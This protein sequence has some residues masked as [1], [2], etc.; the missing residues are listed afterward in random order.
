YPA[1]PVDPAEPEVWH[2]LATAT[3]HLDGITV[4]AADLEGLA[5]FT[6]TP[7]VRVALGHHVG[8]GPDRRTAAG[9]PARLPAFPPRLAAQCSALGR[10][11]AGGFLATG[12]RAARRG[13]RGRRLEDRQ[14]SSYHQRNQA[15]CDHCCL[16]QGPRIRIR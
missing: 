2:R 10:G 9:T 8:E 4:S 6:E 11:A 15:D 5:S 1:L 12:F 13:E 16:C 7:R 14:A 3:L